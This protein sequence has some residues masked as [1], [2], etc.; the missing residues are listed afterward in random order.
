M[1]KIIFTQASERLH[2]K[3][4]PISYLEK[5]AGDFSLKIGIIYYL[6]KCLDTQ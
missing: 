6:K 5:K 1:G 3:L 2:L 4:L